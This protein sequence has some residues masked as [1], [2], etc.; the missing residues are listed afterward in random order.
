M[1]GFCSPSDCFRFVGERCILFR[2]GC[3]EAVGLGSAVGIP[4]ANEAE[5]CQ[6]G[7]D[8][9]A[10][11]GDGC[12]AELDFEPVRGVALRTELRCQ[13]GL[14]FRAPGCQA[15]LDFGTLACT[16]GCRGGCQAELDLGLEDGQAD[17]GVEL[18]SGDALVASS[19]LEDEGELGGVVE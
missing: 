9:D 14:D 8:F 19:E 10:K 17:A 16:G 15:R 18:L 12:Q 6:A 1:S 2:S 7:L 13:A 3:H 5:C 4:G 11:G